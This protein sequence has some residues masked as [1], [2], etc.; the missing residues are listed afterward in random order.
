MLLFDRGF[1]HRSSHSHD[2]RAWYH[3]IHKNASFQMSNMPVLVLLEFLQLG[4]LYG[5]H[6]LPE[7]SFDT[8]LFC[9]HYLLYMFSDIIHASRYSEVKIIFF[10]TITLAAF[11]DQIDGIYSIRRCR[12]AQIAKWF[13][14]QYTS[15][16]PGT[17]LDLLRTFNGIISTGSLMANRHIRSCNPILRRFWMA[18]HVSRLRRLCGPGDV[19]LSY[20]HLFGYGHRFYHFLVLLLCLLLCAVD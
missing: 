10:K 1:E 2:A 12:L 4:H 18:T 16:I 9:R 14:Q 19:K 8:G 3:G 17:P 20:W 5:N 15:G 7:E 6:A 11:Y 13:F